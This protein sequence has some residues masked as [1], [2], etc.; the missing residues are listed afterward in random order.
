M[1]AQVQYCGRCGAPLLQGTAFCGRCG[2]P[3][4]AAAVMPAVATAVAAPPAAPPAAY[5]Y[6]YAQPGAFPAA[7]RV[8]VPQVMV[9]GGVIVILAVAV[10]AITAFA[11]SRALGTHPP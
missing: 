1:A 5:G 2:S 6:R 4:L 3:Q 10:V 9:I 8:K 11:L 7:G